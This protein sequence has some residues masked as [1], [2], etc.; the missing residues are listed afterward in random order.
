VQACGRHVARRQGRVEGG[1]TQKGVIAPA[2][3]TN[4]QEGDLNK[5]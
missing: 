1:V 2:I 5:I 3:G 4:L